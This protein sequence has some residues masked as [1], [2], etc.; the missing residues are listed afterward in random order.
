MKKIIMTVL[1]ALISA[2]LM[3]QSNSKNVYRLRINHADPQLV[4]MLLAGLTNFQTAPE[5][6]A[7]MLGGNGGFGSGGFGGGFSGGSGGNG[8]F[9]S[10]GFGGRSGG[11][12]GGRGN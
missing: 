12:S 2:S 1:F 10:G 4:Y 9:G 5:M 6:S 11:G 8:G 7:L 3:A